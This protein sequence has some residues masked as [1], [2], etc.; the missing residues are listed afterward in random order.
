MQ[1]YSFIKEYIRSYS[2]NYYLLKKKDILYAY[3]YDHQLLSQ[4]KKLKYSYRILISQDNNVYIGVH[5]KKY[6]YQWNVY[7]GEL[8]KINITN[9]KEIEIHC[10]YE[11]SKNVYVQFYGTVDDGMKTIYHIACINK[12]TLEVR[13][14]KNDDFIN[15]YTK[16]FMSNNKIYY[17]ETEFTDYKNVY[18]YIICEP[19][20]VKL[21]KLLTIEGFSDKLF[22]V[23]DNNKYAFLGS[24]STTVISYDSFEYH[25]KMTIIDFVNFQKIDE[26]EINHIDLYRIIS[27]FFH[28][29]HKDYIIYQANPTQCTFK[30]EKWHTYIYD[31]EEKKVIF[32]ASYSFAMDYIRSRQLLV[33][34]TKYG[35]KKTI[36]Y[37]IEDESK[38]DLQWIL[39]NIL[40]KKFLRS[41][42]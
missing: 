38:Q 20:N 26:F 7:N 37:K 25:G 11:D 24:T 6:I 16:T 12:E 33:I 39:D 1:N 42:K 23:S 13:Y 10:I 8:T 30:N 34:G 36:F 4:T 35:G 21:E 32:E 29:N 5:P 14:E 31:I 19:R 17:L 40:T 27:N 22:K 18:N 15:C 3:D 2:S 28:Y 41:C 9:C